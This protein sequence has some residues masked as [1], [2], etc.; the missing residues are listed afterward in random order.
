MGYVF[1]VKSHF[2]RLNHSEVRFVKSHHCCG[3][4]FWCQIEKK[5]Y[6]SDPRTVECTITGMHNTKKCYSTQQTTHSIL[7]NMTHGL[8]Q[9][10]TYYITCY[11]AHSVLHSMIVFPDVLHVLQGVS[12]VCF[13]GRAGAG[14]GRH[15]ASWRAPAGSHRPGGLSS[16]CLRVSS[17]RPAAA[18]GRGPARGR[19]GLRA[20]GPARLGRP[21]WVLSRNLNRAGRIRVGAS[22][23]SHP[24]RRV[25][26]G[27]SVSS[28]PSRRIR[29]VEFKSSRPSRRARWRCGPQAGLA[30]ACPRAVLAPAGPRRTGTGPGPA[31]ARDS[32]RLCWY[33]LPPKPQRRA[34]IVG[35]PWR[36]GR[37]RRRASLSQPGRRTHA[38]E[39]GLAHGPCT[40]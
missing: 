34:G 20:P 29:V 7:H 40:H 37:R 5:S 4:L 31:R 15:A 12:A 30:L 35:R 38:A 14:A 2:S 23:S 18:V 36:D 1:P 22:V 19:C 28:H 11:I 3:I 8:L 33:R 32:L 21:S 13:V 16:C 17:Q 9:K 27:A 6:I 24:S 26:V 39:G 25:Q 10:F